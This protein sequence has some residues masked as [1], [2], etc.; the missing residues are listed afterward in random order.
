MAQLTR[1]F[2][3][4]KFQKSLTKSIKGISTGFNDPDTWISTGNYALNKRI[5][6]DFHK[7]IPLGKVTVFAGES[8][9]LPTTAQVV[10]RH[11]DQTESVVDVGTLRTMFH[12]G[13][14]FEIST[15]DG[16]QKIGAWFDKGVMRTVLIR[17]ENHSTVAA[18]NHLL[19]LPDGSWMMSAD[20]QRG[21]HLLTESGIEEVTHVDV[22]GDQ[23]C[24]DF[25]ILHENHRYWGD[26]FSSHN[27]GKSFIVSGSI[28]KHAQEMG[29]FC[30]VI[31]TEN[32]LD[33]KWLHAVGVDTS[34]EK[35]M[36]ISAS[37]IDDVAKILNDFVDN[38]KT[39]FGELAREERPKV[40]FVIDSLGMLMTPT[41]VAQFTAGDMKGDMG[42]KAK[43][44]KALMTNTT[45]M[46]GDLNI[47][48][49]C[50]NHTY[51]S[52]DMFDPD[53][54]ITGGSG[55]IFAASIIVAMQKLK[56]KKDADG[57][58]ISYVRGIRSKCSV[59][60]T[61]YSKPFEQIELEIPYEEGLSPFS[62][63]FTYF[64]SVGLLPKTGNKYIYKDK[65]GVEHK[66]YEKE[67]AR[68]ENGIL[69]L[70]MAE[71]DESSESL[72]QAAVTDPDSDDDTTD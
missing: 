65:S 33:E 51:K 7:G 14:N 31:D 53:D 52:Q 60:K 34:P 55:P 37:M 19:Q 71:W 12:S 3:P 36:R 9:C 47:G 67:F 27:S 38:Y 21:Q 66:Y 69:D 26:G 62:G 59:V 42:R 16:F 44:L 28:V 63:L 57:N 35:I 6:G 72:E 5:S 8:G 61:R 46:I 18:I 2:D 54:K 45:N 40:L 39:E 22:I 58:K 30:V 50:T 23:E 48:I 4:S 70:I 13:N 41:D 64:E 68:N 1:T 29:I 43:Q 25:E 15:P 56:L 24:F 32:A 20:V 10:I 49:V 17:T 11:P